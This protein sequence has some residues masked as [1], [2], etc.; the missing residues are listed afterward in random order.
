MTL[1]ASVYYSVR[2]SVDINIYNSVWNSFFYSIRVP[3]YYY[4]EDSIYGPV[5]TKID[6][7]TNSQLC[8]TMF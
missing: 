1:E 5:Y 8:M 6:T 2:D 4:I 7:L 3:V